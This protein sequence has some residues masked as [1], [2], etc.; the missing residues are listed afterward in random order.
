MRIQSFLPQLEHRGPAFWAATGTAL[1]GV[2]GWA[3][4]ATGYELSFSLFYLIPIA[5]V[6]WYST[7]AL[8]LVIS[9][10]SAIAWLAADVA[11]GHKYAN[12]ALHI[13]NMCIRLGF[14][15][16]VTGLL[17]ALREA[18]RRE[19]QRARTD[20]LTGLLN[21]RHFREMAEAEVAMA[22]RYGQPLSLAYIDVDDFKAINDRMGHA[23]GD[24]VLAAVGRVLTDA[25]R[26]T[27]LVARVGG[28]EFA[29]FLPQSDEDAAFQAI[30]KLRAALDA[31]MRRRAWPATFS[32][33]VTTFRS[34]P[35]R[36]QDAIDAADRLMYR[37]KN[38][39]KAAIARAAHPS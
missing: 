27:D 35:E 5:L 24:D 31:E 20:H 14:F 17:S 4:Y 30:D 7:R 29:V 12:P 32:I 37:V 36:L 3:D 26:R 15:L 25:L 10:L 11:S 22:R 38:S 2:L 33:G 18:H 28:D 21:A 19:Q 16:V 8:G 13:W 1:V 6:G 39:G 34:A 9:M 23:T